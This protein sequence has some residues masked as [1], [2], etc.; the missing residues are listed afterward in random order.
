M[1]IVIEKQIDLTD[2]ANNPDPK[3]VDQLSIVHE[4]REGEIIQYYLNRINYSEKDKNCYA[5]GVYDQEHGEWSY[6]DYDEISWGRQRTRICGN[7]VE[8]LSI[9]AFPD[10][11]AI[12]VYKLKHRNISRIL[13]PVNP[14]DKR[15]RE[16]TFE[17]NVNQSGQIEYRI[18]PPED[19]EYDC[20]RIIM[21]NGDFSI[22]HITYD[23]SG[24]IEAPKV[25]GEYFVYCVAYKHEGQVNSYDSNVVVLTIQ[26][27][28]ESFEPPYYTKSQVSNLIAHIE[29]MQEQLD[30]LSDEVGDAINVLS[31]VVE[32]E[33]ANP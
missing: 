17:A 25:S 19:E 16:P 32:V 22:D 5:P 1:A 20:Y 26:G 6:V 4:A 29:S 2:Y 24:E 33:N 9:K 3:I 14:P 28:Q 10:V 30:D 8:H 7:R 31:T 11:G 15:K 13:A 18:T 12:A 21:R 27:S 23:L